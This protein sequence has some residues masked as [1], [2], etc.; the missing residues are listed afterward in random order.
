VEI[1]VSEVAEGMLG[2]HHLTWKEVRCDSLEIGCEWFDRVQ[3]AASQEL[4]DLLARF[5]AADGGGIWLALIGLIADDPAEPGELI[6]RL[7]RMPADDI[8]LQLLGL[9][10]RHTVDPDLRL[11]MLAAGR[12]RPA[13]LEALLSRAGFHTKAPARALLELFGA[14]AAD[15]VAAVVRTLRLWFEQVF[16]QEWQAI[17]PIVERDA[18]AKRR[19]AE[20]LS[21]AE[22]VEHATNGIEMVH[23]I[24]VTRVLLMPSY[25]DRPWATHGRHLATSMVCY[26]VAEESLTSSEEEGRRRRILRLSKVL[27]DESRLRALRRLAEGP[28]TLQ[29]LA[30]HLGV[31]KSTMHHHLAAMRSAGMLRIRMNERG[32]SLRP[33]ALEELSNLLG[34]Y[35]GAAEKPARRAPHGRRRGPR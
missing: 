21:T 20:R 19:L 7:E 11:A 13:P 32:Y 22:L 17:R 33:Q 35:L 26:P 23:E 12:G 27:A 10:A 9:H 24:G 6:D 15:A 4:C 34:D 3:T 5:R 25:L 14:D 30:D 31:R 2:L 29:E 16:R 1:R 18:D 28:A 8:W